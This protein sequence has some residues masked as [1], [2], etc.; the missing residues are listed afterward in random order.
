MSSSTPK[1]KEKDEKP[2]GNLPQNKKWAIPVNIT[3]P[4]DDFNKRIPNPA[5]K[6][7]L[8]V[9]NPVTLKFN[10][11]FFFPFHF[12]QSET[13]YAPLPIYVL[14]HI[15]HDSSGKNQPV[16]TVPVPLS[17]SAPVAVRAG[18]FPEAGHSEARGSRLG[19]CSRA[20]ISRENSGGRVCNRPLPETHDEV[21]LCFL[22]STISFLLSSRSRELKTIL[23][24]KVAG[25]L[26]ILNNLSP[27]KKK[28]S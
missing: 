26:I 9:K 21:C 3:S 10:E 18:C 4:C 17:S 5:F 13:F 12:L 15:F 8:L 2:K 25:L 1:E 23:S 11:C 14:L 20:H 6:V 28:N 24:L 7:G 22:A 16:L 19:V 27:I